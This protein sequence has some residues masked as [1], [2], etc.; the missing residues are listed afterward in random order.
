M[1]QSDIFAVTK[2]A[3]AT[4]FAGRAWVRQIQVHTSGSGSPAVVLKDGRS[5]GTTLLS[6]TFTTSNVHSVNI[7]DNGILFTTDV[8]LDLTACEGVTVFL[9]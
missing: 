1:S 6:L 9:S 4:V 2:T 3:D 8:Y 7:P 5:G